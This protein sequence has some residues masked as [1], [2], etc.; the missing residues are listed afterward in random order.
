M[1]NWIKIFATML[2]D[3]R[4]ERSLKILLSLRDPDFLKQSKFVDKETKKVKNLVLE[5]F[6]R[7][8]IT[9]EYV[10]ASVID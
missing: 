2:E 10:A 8:T 5:E 1:K 9:K 7:Q 6:H 3:V 4:P